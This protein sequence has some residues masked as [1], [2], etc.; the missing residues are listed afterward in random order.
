MAAAAG[1]RSARAD[2]R[3]PENDQNVV[4]QHSPGVLPEF[5][6]FRAGGTRGKLTAG[7][8]GHYQQSIAKQRSGSGATPVPCYSGGLNPL[9]AQTSLM[10]KLLA[11]NR[12]EIAIRI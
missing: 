3:A 9:R 2:I 7:E 11:L 1:A 10:K 8:C 5:S 6:N 4:A 12:G